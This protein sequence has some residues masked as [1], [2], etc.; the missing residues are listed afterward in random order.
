MYL[1]LNNAEDIYIN[2]INVSIVTKGERFAVELAP[3]TSA[4]FHIIPP[5]K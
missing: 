3:S 1:D 5:E 2:S 4:S